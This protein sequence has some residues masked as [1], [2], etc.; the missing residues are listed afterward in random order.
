MQKLNQREKQ[1]VV[2]VIFLILAA[3]ACR[4]SQFD[5]I[6]DTLSVILGFLRPGIYIGMTFA[7][8]FS[9]K[10]RIL[11]AEVKKYLLLSA[12]LMIFWLVVRTI[13]YNVPDDFPDLQ[14]YCWYC[15]YI[16]MLLIPML[17]VFA[18]TCI[19]MPEEYTIPRRVKL[20]CLPALL[21]IAAVL[22]NDL[23][24]TAFVFQGG[25]IDRGTNYTYGPVY[26][27][28]VAL[29]ALEAVALMGFL[30]KKCR[31]PGKG[32]RLLLPLLPA[33]IG[34]VY[35]I[36][37][38]VRAPYIKLIAGDVTAV[39]WLIMITTYEACIRARLIP[40]NTRYDELFR[41]STIMARITDE[42]YGVLYCSDGG[43]SV[44][45]EIL[46]Q[47][48]QGPVMLSDNIRLSGAAIT[49]G[50]VVWQEDMTEL[51]G[52]LNELRETKE[53]L[54]G[55]NDFLREETKLK[56]RETHIAEQD[57]LY[58]VIQR[59]SKRQIQR[60][61]ELMDAFEQTDCEEARKKL[62]GKMAVIGA[63]IKR[64]SNLVFTSD[65]APFLDVKDIGLAFGE[66]I[67]N[68]ELYGVACGLGISLEKQLDARHAMAM[69][70]L[71]ESVAE[72]FDMSVLTIV[73][74]GGDRMDS[75][76]L[77]TDSGSDLTA[78]A[79]DTVSVL[80]D[81]DGEWQ[82]VQRLYDGGDAL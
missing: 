38:V 16:P 2:M 60:L 26:F 32:R 75:I 41:A 18:A 30:W 52:V 37:Y 64:R 12:A 56:A 79:S 71:F 22:T 65:K 82:L 21:V 33:F 50:H 69:Y 19:N 23:H 27:A 46:R 61:A 25:I 15:Y 43:M 70:D 45:P 53:N 4:H 11:S 49:G 5:R 1:I 72:H 34:F 36:A 8:A 54:E 28:A 74:N 81:E 40:S 17:G 68:L 47:T 6:E 77:N 42:N 24:Q 76:T 3:I 55:S 31:L 10:Q 39:I 78:L 80:R 63:Y 35:V 13:R 9:V 48:E 73:I 14:R 44:C 59:G 67:S 20:L 7:W 62:L 66:S 58:G 57:R 51:I 29:V